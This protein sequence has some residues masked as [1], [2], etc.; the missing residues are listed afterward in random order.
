MKN[1]TIL[2][3]IAIAALLLLLLQG[4]TTLDLIRDRLP[5]WPRPEQPTPDAPEPPAE[6]TPAPCRTWDEPPVEFRGD[7]LWKPVSEHRALVILINT[8]FRGHV[9]RVEL[10]RVGTWEIIERGR[11]AGDTHNGCRPHYRFAHPGEHYGH[12][13]FVRVTLKD[14]SE[15]A[16]I[17]PDGS[18]RH[19]W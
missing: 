8:Q 11:F 10:L 4:C 14:G 9:D 16:H 5:E 6:P 13:I 18:H 19:Q 15:R 3:P 2:Y 7:N 1:K 12:D 17:I